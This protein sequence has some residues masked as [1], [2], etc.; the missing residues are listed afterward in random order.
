MADIDADQLRREIQLILKDA[1]LNTLSSKKVRQMLEQRFECDLTERKKE[2]DDILMA[3]I[4]TRDTTHAQTEEQQHEQVE[5]SD[6]EK[7]STSQIRRN[8]KHQRRTAEAKSQQHRPPT[9]SD[10]EL[11]MEIHQQEN[12]PSLRHSRPMVGALALSWSRCGP[13]NTIVVLLKKSTSHCPANKKSSTGKTERRKTSFNKD[14]DLSDQLAQIVGANQVRPLS[15]MC[16]ILSSSLLDLF[17][18]LDPKW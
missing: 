5:T 11:A 12:R 8:G 17:R 2:I 6:D 7:P 4:T 13:S 9:K 16:D 10:E 1:D 14:L 3:E 18:C 15:I